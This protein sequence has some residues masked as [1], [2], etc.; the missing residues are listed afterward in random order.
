MIRE[1]VYMDNRFQARRFSRG[2]GKLQSFS[3]NEF[4]STT[5]CF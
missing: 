2:V 4:D 1:N 3:Y 5:V